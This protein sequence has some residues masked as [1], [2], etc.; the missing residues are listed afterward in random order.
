MGVARK[1]AP[2]LLFLAIGDY[3]SPRL[4]LQKLADRWAK[5]DLLLDPVFFRPGD[6]RLDRAA[7]QFHN[8]G[9]R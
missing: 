6:A 1:S 5:D 4:M 7:P 3:I 8:L 2:K 9:W